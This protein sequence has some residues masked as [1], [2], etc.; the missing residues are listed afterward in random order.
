MRMDTSRRRQ[1]WTESEAGGTRSGWGLP[2]N[3]PYTRT[4]NSGMKKMARKVAASM[5]PVT[6]MPMAFCAPEPAPVAEGEREARRELKAM[7]GHQNG[8]Q[9]QTCAPSSVAWINPSALLHAAP[10]QTRRSECRSWP[11]DRSW[12]GCRPGSR[13]RWTGR[14]ISDDASERAD[15]AQRHEPACTATAA[16][17]QLS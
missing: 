2:W 1:G 7:R 8:T 11:R 12:S 5:P 6:Q 15:H 16:C 17:D 3:V 13:R 10:W 14:A 4:K 9:S